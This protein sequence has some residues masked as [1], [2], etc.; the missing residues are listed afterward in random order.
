VGADASEA[1]RLEAGIPAYGVDV[2]EG[3]I[4]PETRLEALVSYTKG[5][6]IGQETVA[7]VKYRG[8]INRGLSGLVLDGETVPSPGD[9]I[10]A[11]DKDIGRV[12][13]AVRSIALGRL[14]PSVMS[15][16]STSSR[17][18]RCPSSQP[19]VSSRA[20]CPICPS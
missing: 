7:R 12:T 14:S 4:L 1:L 5:C 19:T 13:S 10:F 20:T 2:D 9:P 3:V 18:A 17:G 6:Y 16:V 11:E 15:A 8:H